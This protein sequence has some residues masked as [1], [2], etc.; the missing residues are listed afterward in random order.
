[1]NYISTSALAKELNIKASELFDKLKALTWIERKNDKWLLTEQGK[2]RGGQIR[3]SAK[4]G[5]FIVWPES[6]IFDQS[7]IDFS[8]KQKSAP[9]NTIGKYFNISSFLLN[10]FSS[11]SGW[12]D[13]ALSAQDPH[14]WTIGKLRNSLGMGNLT[15]EASGGSYMLWPGTL[16][17]H[18]TLKE[19]FGDYPKEKEISIPLEAVA[20]QP[21]DDYREKWDAKH[22]TLDGHYVRSRAEVI[23][24]NLLFQYG[25]VHAYERKIIIGDEE[26]LSDFYL[27]AG[28]V[29]IEF[30]GM[31]GDTKYL[32]KKRKKIE[33][34]KK[35][36]IPLIE[37]TDND[38]LS[39]DDH[40]PRKLK[41]FG[42][43]V[44]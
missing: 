13:K 7:E 38:I 44:Y 41:D 37:L 25:L 11:E 15:L 28:K 6:I 31:E 24:D 30:W 40:L 26:L 1:M 21:A 17:Q 23:I 39:L 43:K 14:G 8:N 9:S 16:V 19:G 36:N 18:K 34:Y 2:E 12:L 33:F 35:N 27:P 42:I 29:Y 4:F 20:H 22:R 5:D 10:L 32:E 3:T